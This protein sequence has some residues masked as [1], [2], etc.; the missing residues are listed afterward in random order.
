MPA[1]ADPRIFPDPSAAFPET[2]PVPPDPLARLAADHAEQ[3]HLCDTLEAIA[4][5]LPRLPERR[6]CLAALEVLERHL[7]M[8]HA[9]EELGLFPLLRARC[10]PEDR[11][12]AIL[13]E[14]EDEHVDDEALLTEV[15]LTLRALA[16]D[17]GPERDPAVAGY[18]LRGFFESQ[19][20]HIAWEEAT[21]MPLALA[22]LLP[23]DLATL[24]DVMD[25]NHR[26]RTPDV[27]RR[28]DAA[29]G[30]DAL[31]D[32]DVPIA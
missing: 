7:P 21:I 10:E 3:R 25:R 28:R 9:D 29:A 4:D 2:P 6:A 17:R 32:I 22:R 1:L 13:R 24:D 12:D 11:I 19:R 8:H 15:V 18:V 23:C 31:G 5:L 20:R 14:L 26:G 30:G 27:F 16:A